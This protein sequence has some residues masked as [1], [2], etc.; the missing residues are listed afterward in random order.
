MHHCVSSLEKLNETYVDDNGRPYQDVRVRHTIVLDDPFDD[1]EGLARHV[2]ES[3][4]EPTAE[5]LRVGCAEMAVMVLN[6]WG[7]LIDLCEC[8]CVCTE[9]L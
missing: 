2:P 9:T 6:G 3:S 8:V 7:V 5:Q 1:P 4:P